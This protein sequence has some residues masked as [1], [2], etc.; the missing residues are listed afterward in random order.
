VLVASSL[1]LFYAAARFG[2]ANTAVI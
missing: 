2:R 1:I